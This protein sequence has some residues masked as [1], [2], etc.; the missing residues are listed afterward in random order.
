MF[1]FSQFSGKTVAVLYSVITVLTMTTSAS[2]RITFISFSTDCKVRCVVYILSC[3]VL[4]IDMNCSLMYSQLK[5]DY[6]YN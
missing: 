1:M 4:P 5:H 2:H 3:N 6:V